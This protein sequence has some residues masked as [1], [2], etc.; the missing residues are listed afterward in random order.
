MGNKKRIIE[1]LILVMTIV[2][3]IVFFYPKQRVIGG[4]GG[5]YGPG[6]TAYR[7]DYSC[8]GIKADVPPGPSCIDCGISYY[9]FGM[10]TNRVCTMETYHADGTITRAPVAC[11]DDTVQESPDQISSIATVMV[12][13][14]PNPTEQ[15]PESTLSVCWQCSIDQTVTL[16]RGLQTPQHLLQSNAIK[17]GEEFDVN[18]YFEIF[19]HLSMEPGYVLDYVY[20]YEEL[21]GKPVLYA[22]RVEEAPFKTFS[23]YS[24]ARGEAAGSYLDHVQV[25]GSKEGFFQFIVL[26]TI[27]EQ[28]YLW[29]HATTNDTTIITNQAALTSH[30]QNVEQTCTEPTQPILEQSTKLLLTPQVEFK[31]DLVELTIMAFQ[32]A[33]GLQRQTYLINRN[34]PHSFDESTELLIPYFCGVVP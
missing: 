31:N 5:F 4:L 23:E 22:R 11:E 27:G 19:N 32:S 2:A 13:I 10:I 30:L 16:I 9:C 28:F 18:A 6:K 20:W 34:F 33:T 25:D 15:P 26:H 14:I 29:W 1:R 21:G 7:E 24:A 3:W 8:I 12:T 17:T